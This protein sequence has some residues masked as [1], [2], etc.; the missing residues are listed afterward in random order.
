LSEQKTAE[1][2]EVRPFAA[3]LQELA[4][5]QVHNEASEKLHALVDAVTEHGVKGSMTLTLTVAPIAKG[6]V[7][8]LT[9]GATVT[10]KPPAAAQTSAFFVDGK[11]NL[12]RRDPR[13]IEIPMP[14]AGVDNLGRTAVQ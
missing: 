2:P 5:G 3:V 6:D 14:V 13:Q 11:G 1:G 12:S 4:R 10:S 7:S 8:V 9:V